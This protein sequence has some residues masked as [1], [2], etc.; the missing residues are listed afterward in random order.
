MKALPPA[1]PFLFAFAPILGV[2]AD[3]YPVVPPIDLVRSLIVVTCVVLV[4]YAFSY[5]LVR[6][7]RKAAAL[8]VLA[9][10]VI[11][12]YGPVRNLI[13][14]DILRT[15]FF[16][17]IWF[18]I[19]VG[20]Y[21]YAMIRL[22]KMAPRLN[23]LTPALT[24]IGIAAVAAP[25]VVAASV[26]ITSPEIRNP[27]DDASNPREGKVNAWTVNSEQPDI[28]YIVLDG[29]GREDILRSR[30]GLKNVRLT[31]S[32]RE[33]GFYVADKAVS[34]YSFTHLSLAATLNLTYLDKYI[35]RIGDV[36]ASKEGFQLASKFFTSLIADPEV[37]RFLRSRGYKLIGNR[38][39]YNVTRAF[40]S[41]FFVAR[42]SLNEFERVLVDNTFLQPILGRL[43]ISP[44]DHLRERILSTL[45]Q[46]PRIARLDPPKF[47]FVHIVSPHTPFLFD[48]RGEPAPRS[49][50]Y[51]ITAWHHEQRL[52]NGWAEWYREGYAAQV[53][54]LGYHVKRAIEGILA[55][56]ARPPIIIVQSDHGPRLGMTADVATSDVEERLAI[57][58]AFY[59][60]GNKHE[61]LYPRISAVNTFRLILNEYFDQDYPVLDDRSYM[62]LLDLNMVDVTERISSSSP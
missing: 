20:T 1:Y 11:F 16:F 8:T 4:G 49:E 32:L 43:R 39:G 48:K 10:I 50:V 51:D 22:R 44:H 13:S 23:N 5:L 12:A 42:F 62:S 56:S 52:I 55:N 34:N 19:G 33:L 15:R 18:G 36:P 6:D 60:P 26:A 7:V 14:L 30:Y 58:S 41:E 21:L 3:N 9:I 25:L 24:W 37:G 59:L 40:S 46:L 29:H 54:G 17:P 38:S 27:D 2:F 35:E 61:A 45:E 47:V 53:Q 57:L 28:Y 31:D